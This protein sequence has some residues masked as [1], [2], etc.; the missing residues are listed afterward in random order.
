MQKHR[1]LRQAAA[2]IVVLALI[3][4]VWFALSNGQKEAPDNPL[5]SRNENSSHMLQ[6]EPLTM[7]L[8]DQPQAP[9][10]AP[11]SE[12]PQVSESPEP[13]PEPTIE[14]SPEPTPEPTA[15]PTETPEPSSAPT[16]EPAKTQKPSSTKAPQPD[17][18]LTPKPDADPTAGTGETTKPTEVVYFTTT[19]LNGSTIPQNELS[20]QIIH[21]QPELRVQSTSVEVNGSEVPQFSGRVQLANGQNSIKVTVVYVDPENRQIQVSKTYT[22]Y[23]VPD[24]L[25][26]TTDLTDRTVNQQGFA[27]TAYAALGS[28]K[29][30]LSVSVNGEQIGSDSNRYKTTLNEGENLIVLAADG[31]GQHLEQ[32][33]TITVELPD[34]IEIITDLYDHE[35][36]DP[37]FSF[38]ASIA[39]GTDRAS[40]TVVA[41]GVTLSG[42]SGVYSCQLSR[43]NNLIRLK[44][45]DVDGKEYTQSYTISY[46]HYIICEADEAD[47]TMPKMTC[48]ISNG[49]E[50]TGSLYTLQ[51]SA[52][53]GDGARIYGDHITVQLNGRTLEDMWEDEQR[54]GYRLELT[55]G[56]NDVVI[57]VWDYEDRYTIYRYSLNCTAVDEGGMKGTATV[58]VDANVLSLGELI[59]ATKVD[60]LEGQNA[61]YAVAQVLESYGYEYQYSGDLKN[62][63]YLAHLIKPG[64]TNGWV[65]PEEL[66]N[67]IDEDGLMWTN[68][69]HT[70]SLGEQ[71]FT[72]GSGWMYCVNGVFPN[73]SL[74]EC[75]L[76]DGDVLRLRFTLAYG[77][78]IGGSSSSGAGSNYDHQW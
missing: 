57:T 36:D 29:A 53:T 61:V 71:D 70:D 74:S 62:G 44:A 35:V 31:E 77:K 55:G 56:L 52:Q 6:E 76:Q 45:T 7:A 17:P 8:E 51:V 54:T 38:Q 50:I 67:D 69:Y 20:F 40:L 21:K 26:I 1:F 65:I 48:N 72:Q 32:R 9:D 27:F 46:H 58:I 16:S 23:V 13:T 10:N 3:A 18:L 60:I 68:I 66:E 41:N 14:P 28:R 33:Y 73:Y 4:G 59:P 15:A 43:G 49:M 75:Y 39:G 19:I 12:T 25:V 42:D 47:E 24:E 2:L 5:E 11:P 34:N 64:I 30:T 22:V 63:F 37:A 78:D